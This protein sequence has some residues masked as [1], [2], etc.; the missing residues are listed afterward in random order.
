LGS[1]RAHESDS[2]LI[3]QLRRQLRGKINVHSDVSGV[4]RFACSNINNV[5]PIPRHCGTNDGHVLVVELSGKGYLYNQL[6]ETPTEQ[7][8][9]FL[10]TNICKRGKKSRDLLNNT[11]MISLRPYF[12]MKS[13][14]NFCNEKVS[15]GI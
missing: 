13:S 5:T 11:S 6:Y 4:P 10:K 7:L 1:V 3:E 14:F 12:L 9:D 15:L 8:S 2:S